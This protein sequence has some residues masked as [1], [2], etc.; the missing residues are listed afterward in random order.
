MA[1]NQFIVGVR[2]IKIV[3]KVGHVPAPQRTLWQIKIRKN[4]YNLLIG[5][6]NT[7]LISI[8]MGKA[9]LTS[10]KS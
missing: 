9:Q 1:E 7:A 2:N 10:Q 6:W 5:T 8:R 3:V 4:S